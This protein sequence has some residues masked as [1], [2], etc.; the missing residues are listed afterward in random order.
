MNDDGFWLFVVAIVI[1][2]VGTS[3]SVKYATTH[4]IRKEAC[5]AGVGEYYISTNS[6]SRE[7]RWKTAK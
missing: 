4:D 3:V 7:F 6:Y 5:D 2:F 1:T